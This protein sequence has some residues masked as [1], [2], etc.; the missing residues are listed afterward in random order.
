MTRTLNTA[1]TFV[2]SVDL[3][4]PYIVEVIS[5]GK[6]HYWRI[7]NRR[8]GRI[9]AHSEQYSQRRHAAATAGKFAGDVGLEISTKEGT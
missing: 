7:R 6:S 2:A 3:A 9:L 5:R 4:L 8:N 1:R